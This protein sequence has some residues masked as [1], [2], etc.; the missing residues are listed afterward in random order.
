MRRRF[1]IQPGMVVAAIVFATIPDLVH[2]LPVVA[3]ALFGEGTGH[4]LQAY[5]LATPGH[6]P[7][8][9]GWAVLASHHLHCTMHS[10]MVAGGITLA[11]WLLLRSVWFPLWGWWSHI[12]ID[13]PTHSAD[14]YPTPV[15]YPLSERSFD[16]IA[17]NTP[18][19]IVVNYV[20]IALAWG[21]I[22]WSRQER[23]APW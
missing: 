17:W 10:A 15:L 12:L 3:W 5:A 22:V 7:A 6:E 20:G 18:W 8:M 16:G 23:R 1:N 21:Y 9:P 2:L 4:A 11:S 14:F 13:V 19:F